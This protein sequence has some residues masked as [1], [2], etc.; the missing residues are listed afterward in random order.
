M[1]GGQCDAQLVVAHAQLGDL[2]AQALDPLAALVFW[3]AAGLEGIQVAFDRGLG[4]GDLGGDGRKLGLVLVAEGFGLGPGRGDGLLE[5][6]GALEGV[7]QSLEDGPVEL[8]GGQP[9][10]RPEAAQA[11]HPAPPLTTLSPRAR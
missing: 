1:D 5:Q 6:V 10:G 8:L 11:A 3:Q 7:Q 4:A 2:A 9:V